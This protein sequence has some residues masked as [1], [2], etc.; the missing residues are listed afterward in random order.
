[1]ANERARREMPSTVDGTAPGASENVVRWT[2]RRDS[3]HARGHMTSGALL[4]H[5]YFC[6][7]PGVIWGA[8]E[9]KATFFSLFP[10]RWFVFLPQLDLW[11]YFFLFVFPSLSSFFV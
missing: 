4:T 10:I 7:V 2:L 9:V 5:L 3:H 8:V 6:F 1:M 11:G